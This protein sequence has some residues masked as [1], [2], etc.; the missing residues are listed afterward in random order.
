[1]Q[2]RVDDGSC[3]D[4][5]DPGPFGPKWI[6]HL[7]VVEVPVPVG[8]EPPLEPIVGLH[9]DHEAVAPEAGALGSK[10]LGGAAFANR[11]A[12]RVDAGT[13]VDVDDVAAHSG[14]TSLPLRLMAKSR[15]SASASSS[16][17]NGPMASPFG[18]QP[19]KHPHQYQPASFS[20]S[21]FSSAYSTSG[22]ACGSFS[23]DGSL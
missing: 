10:D 1:M 19:G 11:M 17:S 23:R 6:L 21:S 5:F 15:T 7:R 4:I 20:P 14:R 22:K 18:R 13:V 2:E 8:Y 16:V 9:D 12:G 3:R